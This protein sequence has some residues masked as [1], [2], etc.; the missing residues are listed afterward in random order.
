VSSDQPSQC[1]EQEVE[2]GYPDYA[3]QKELPR[4]DVSICCGVVHNEA[5]DDKKNVDTGSSAF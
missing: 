5:A 4:S 1:R 3:S 2:R